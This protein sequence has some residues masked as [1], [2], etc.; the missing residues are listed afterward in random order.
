MFQES[1]H[2]FYPV[3]GR[4]TFLFVGRLPL[5]KVP[6]PKTLLPQLAAGLL[7][8]VAPRSFR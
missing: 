2:H 1:G 3:L 5:A 8:L 7:N 6:V 4:Q